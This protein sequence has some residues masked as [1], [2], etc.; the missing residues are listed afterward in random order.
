MDYGIFSAEFEEEIK[1]IQLQTKLL[2][3]SKYYKLYKSEK[4]ETD[5]KK[6]GVVFA[7]YLFPYCVIPVFSIVFIS[8]F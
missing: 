3:R 4:I 8:C 1:N 7:Y 2:G 6:V 5:S